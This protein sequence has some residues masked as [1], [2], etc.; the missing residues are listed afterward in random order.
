MRSPAF[1]LNPFV[2]SPVFGSLITVCS[3]TRHVDVVAKIHLP[4]YVTS[5]CVMGLPK[6]GKLV[7][8]WRMLESPYKRIL[9]SSEPTAM[10]PSP[11]VA[12][13]RN[14]VP[15]AKSCPSRYPSVGLASVCATPP[16]TRA[17]HRT[18]RLSSRPKNVCRPTSV[19]DDLVSATMSLMGT[20]TPSFRQPH[21]AITHSRSRSIWYSFSLRPA[22]GDSRNIE[23][24]ASAR[25]PFVGVIRDPS[26]SRSS[27]R[28]PAFS[29]APPVL[30]RNTSTALPRTRN[31]LSNAPIFI[32][33]ASSPDCVRMGVP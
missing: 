33:S 31:E 16:A 3:N 11:V 27:T 5:M 21:S 30:L 2:R 13:H 1:V 26:A 29:S 20:S 9:P 22:S 28:T 7:F 15:R 18:K 6:P 24:S 19:C 12:M 8:A 25:K 4:S 23:R 14:L 10:H 32:S 17:S